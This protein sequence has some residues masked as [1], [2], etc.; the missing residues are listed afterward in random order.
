[1]ST[2]Q[3]IIKRAR[4]LIGALGRGETPT[5][6]E[7]VD[8]LYILNK[9]FDQLW[10]QRNAVYHIQEQS[11]SV[12][13]ITHTIGPTGDFVFTRPLKI[14]SAVHRLTGV[15]YP[16]SIMTDEQYRQE[17]FKTVTS[18]LIT[19]LWYEPLM[20]DGKLH[21]YPVPST[22]STVLLRSRAQIESFTINETIVLP[23][24][25][26]EMMAYNLAPRLAPEY[27]R[28]VPRDVAVFA[29]TSLKNIKRINRPTPM[30]VIEPSHGRRYSIDSDS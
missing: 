7:N 12:T 24:G 28:D 6:A 2:A 15:D 5:D 8:D 30:A 17:V 29:R 11:I 26:E 21:F 25:Y 1:M 20:P 27:Q 13:A 22:T 18:S 10:L 23:P 14:E 19:D 4:R 3:D 9:M 16:I